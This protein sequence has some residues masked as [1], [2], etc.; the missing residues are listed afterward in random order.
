V[1]GSDWVRVR[2]AGLHWHVAP[3]L[4]GRLFG[5]DGIR[6]NEWLNGGRAR[7]V[8]TGP[9]QT[10]YRVILPGLDF[11]LKHYHL[12]NARAW[13]RQLLRPPK[14]RAEYERARAVA[15]RHVPTVTAL[16]TGSRGL[17]PGPSY[18]LTRSLQNTEPLSTFI[19]TALPVFSAARRAVL[20]Q[21]L[22]RELGKLVARMHE[23]GIFHADLHPGNLLIR[24]GDGDVVGLFVIDLHDIRLGR[25][26]GWRAA[27]RNLIILNRW[28]VLRANR[29]DR[30]RFF[31]AYCAERAALAAAAGRGPELWEQHHAIRANLNRQLE[32]RTWKSN[33]R[34]WR[35]REERCLVTN[36]YYRKVRSTGV[37][38]YAVQDLDQSS[39]SALLADPDA[40]FKL[41]GTV[42]LKHSPSSTVAEIDVRVHDTVRR[43]IYKR[44][45]A[46]AWTDPWTGLVRWTGAMKSWIYG[47]ALRDRLLPTARPLA[48]FHRRRRGLPQEGYLLTEKIPDAEDLRRHVG[49]LSRLPGDERQATL[50]RRIEEVARLV[51]ELHRRRLAHRDLKAA[52]ILVQS[53]NLVQSPKSKVQ[54]PKL[55]RE[56]NHLRPGTSDFGPLWLIDL[57]GISRHRRLPRARR[58]QNLARLHASF[59][60]DGGLT[61]TDKLRFLRTYLQWGLSGKAGWKRWWRDIEQATQEKVTRNL[62]NGRPLT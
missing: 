51:R 44:F 62:R 9:H 21:R 22:A 59:L 27:R 49:G 2:S 5:P 12:M 61:R 23:A 20:G 57:A 50:R 7:I 19:E 53:P 42:I 45:G 34:F 35:Q 1:I 29:S 47:H 28:F 11:H 4:C 37:A 41:P 6:L 48:M 31:R 33:L 43:V 18:L 39:L 25:P 8:K 60:Q 46:T 56:Q 24:L 52:N 36:R 17:G 3:E 55:T 15:A 32:K 40:P 26:L 38:G 58:L 16:G 10:V 14:A 13:L 54:S 30:V